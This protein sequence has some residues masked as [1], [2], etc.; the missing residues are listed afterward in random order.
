MNSR[1]S[2]RPI[3]A[4]E[5]D[6]LG[7]L[8]Q[9]EAKI[10]RTPWNISQIENE[11]KQGG[12]IW[13]Y[14]DDETDEI[15]SGY[16]VFRLVSA[17]KFAEILQIGVPFEYRGLGFG[18]KLIQLVVSESLRNH[19]EKILLN[20][21]VDSAAAIAL[22]QKNRFVVTGTR[23]HFYS[24]GASAHQMELLLNPTGVETVDH[25]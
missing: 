14:T 7:R 16:V 13:I 1:F 3:A 18:T 5:S 17:G 6:E 25:F 9:I 22:Y 4:D 11:L 2:P 21:D 24:N 8:V 12:K 23:K 19:L 15:I 20:V 10:Q